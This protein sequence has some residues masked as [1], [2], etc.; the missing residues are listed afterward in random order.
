MKENEK[1]QTRPVQAIRVKTLFVTV[2]LKIQPTLGTGQSE[3]FIYSIRYLRSRRPVTVQLRRT[4][5]NNSALTHRNTS[6][7]GEPA[8]AEAAAVPTSSM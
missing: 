6:S 4:L 2:S 1:W 5:Y 3:A 8:R 7:A